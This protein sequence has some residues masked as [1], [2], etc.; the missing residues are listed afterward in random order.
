MI[1]MAASWFKHSIHQV[2]AAMAGLAEWRI[3]G[4]AAPRTQGIDA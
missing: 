3:L 2:T 4:E 1:S